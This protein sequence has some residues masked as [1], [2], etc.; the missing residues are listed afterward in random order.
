MRKLNDREREILQL[1]GDG[2]GYDKIAAVLGVS[3][4]TV[5]NACAAIRTKLKLNSLAELIRFAV[6]EKPAPFS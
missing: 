2:N 3:P 6:R 5:I 4:K 1:L